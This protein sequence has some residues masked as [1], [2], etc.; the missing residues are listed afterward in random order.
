M[1]E[2]IAEDTA[3]DI[4]E[5]TAEDIAEDTAEDTYWCLNDYSY[6]LTVGSEIP[7]EPWRKCSIWA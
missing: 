4:A 1:A 3:E 5:D 2:D 6:G 7:G